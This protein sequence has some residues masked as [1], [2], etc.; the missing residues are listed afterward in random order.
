MS[1]QGI[2]PRAVD[3]PQWYQDVIREA[4]LADQSP[5]RGSMVF[6]PDGYALWEAES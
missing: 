6:R 4:R 2:T 1:E 5:T 3:F